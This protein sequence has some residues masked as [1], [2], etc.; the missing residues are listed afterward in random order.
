MITIRITHPREVNR[1]TVLGHL[2]G[3]DYVRGTDE[4]AWIDVLRRE[5][6]DRIV[7]SMNAQPGVSASIVSEKE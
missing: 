6:A 2:A 4:A 7:N 3:R 1:D 5:E